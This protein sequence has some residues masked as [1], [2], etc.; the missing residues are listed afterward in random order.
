MIQEK[1]DKDDSY[2]WWEYIVLVFLI[3]GIIK[4]RLENKKKKEVDVNGTL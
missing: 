4:Y 2:A 3:A 1:Y